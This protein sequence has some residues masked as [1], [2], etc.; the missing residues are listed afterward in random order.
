M[1]IS[2][3]WKCNGIE[4]CLQGEDEKSCDSMYCKDNSKCGTGECI[5]ESWKCD[6]VFDC[7]DDSD[8]RDCGSKTKPEYCTPDR[9]LVLC[10]DKTHCTPHEQVCDGV[11]NCPDNSDEM[12][13]AASHNC[14]NITSKI[15]N[16]T[17]CTCPP[18]YHL[19][20]GGACKDIDE[21]TQY[22]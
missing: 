12:L 14:V 2:N 17:L 21:C 5:Q 8:E 18:G 6:G 13:C 4:E 7:R 9:G 22:G 3:L 11:A 16:R 15:S 20:T 19:N 10:G 1:C